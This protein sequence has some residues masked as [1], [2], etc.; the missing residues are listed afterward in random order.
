MAWLQQG[1]DGTPMGERLAALGRA[2]SLHET[3]RSVGDGVLAG[4]EAQALLELRSAGVLTQAELARRISLDKSTV[5]RLV[6]GLEARDW[7]ARRPS[8][9]DG[10]AV[11]V[12]LRWGG[13]SVADR[14]AQAQEEKFRALLARIPEQ[15]RAGVLRSLEVLTGVR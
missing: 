1:N 13:R 5:S 11:L 8:P 6:A 7:V 12:E 3:D 15:E 14:L 4:S 2:L 10:R 9:D